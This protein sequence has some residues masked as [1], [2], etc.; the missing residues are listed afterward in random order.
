MYVYVQVFE[1]HI[2]SSNVVK[3]CTRELCT[4]TSA[5]TVA[6]RIPCCRQRLC[7]GKGLSLEAPE[8]ARLTVHRGHGPILAPLGDRR[9]FARGFPRRYG[10]RPC[11]CRGRDRRLAPARCRRGVRG[12]P[13]PRA[14]QRWG[15][16][17][18]LCPVRPPRPGRCC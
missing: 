17:C 11:S 6:T 9:L 16:Q 1:T 14:P 10:T 2:I 5:D 12:E 7:R 4:A 3:I 13:F 18:P 15:A 8:W